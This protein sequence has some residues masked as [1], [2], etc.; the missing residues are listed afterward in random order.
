MAA[1]K[2]DNVKAAILNAAERLLSRQP[3]VSLADIAKEAQIS[4]GTLFYHYRSKTDIILDISERYWSQLS[5][6][7]LAWVDDPNKITTP[8]RLARYVMQRGVFDKSGPL[9]LHLFVDAISNDRADS[10]SA[11]RN[12]LI[13]QYTHFKNILKTRILE[14]NPGAAGE[15]LAWLLL[16]M[17]DGLTVHHSLQNT[18][19]DIDRYIEWLAGQFPESV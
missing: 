16:L 3:D 10:A 11:V 4:K 19:I 15:E 6:A 18:E 9:R 7:L 5:D 2:N 1:P 14:R 13:E 12:A 17:V 8:V